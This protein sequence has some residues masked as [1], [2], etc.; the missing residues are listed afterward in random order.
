MFNDFNTPVKHNSL[1]QSKNIDGEDIMVDQ[2]SLEKNIRVLSPSDKLSKI[3]GPSA[4][5]LIKTE[6]KKS[7]VPR[8]HSEMQV[9]ASRDSNAHDM[10]SQRPLPKFI[11]E[12]R[13][14]Q[15]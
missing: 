10:E 6:V 7:S 5:R 12:N 15:L 13:L 4:A 14:D 1:S 8:Q 11:C 2:M 3:S 9:V